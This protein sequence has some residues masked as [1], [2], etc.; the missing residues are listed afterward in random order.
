MTKIHSQAP[1]GVQ[2]GDGAVALEAPM[3]ALVVLNA[4]AGKGDHATAGQT[5]ER[6]LGGA[7]IEFEILKAKKKKKA[8]KKLRERLTD[9]YDLVIACGGDGT[10]A[11]AFQALHGTGI[12][13]AIIPL[14]TGNIVA[15]EFNIPVDVDGA[16]ALITG[17][18]QVK[19]ID[20]M[21][22]RDGIYVLSAGVG[23][24]AAVVAETSE[25]SKTRFGRLAYI[26]SIFKVF[27]SPPRPVQ[28]TLDGVV[29]RYRAV[30]VAVNNC[31]TLARAVY[32]RG[33]DIRADDGRVDV[34]I[35]G[36]ETPLDYFL[37]FGGI[38]FGRRKKARFMTAT[39]SVVIDARH[40]M[41][42]Q[43]DGDVI[44][45]T[46]LEIEVLPAALSILV[47]IV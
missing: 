17:A 39:K 31:G 41:T 38:L 37:Y 7:G 20:A 5:I 44:G 33:P 22:I 14:G 12:P 28:V 19:K 35:L 2:A 27:G 1:T 9:K 6:V 10:V 13:L 11:G 47:P 24:N 36:M 45:T 26:R 29:H 4:G 43:A 34:W 40:P 8:L 46:P 32:P 23:I 21:K 25:D 42:A 16:L 15:R 30:E 18:S 3:K